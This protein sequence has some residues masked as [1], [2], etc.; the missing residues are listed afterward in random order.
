MGA[1]IWPA[2]DMRRTARGPMNKAMVKL[3][4]ERLLSC[5]DVAS[6]SFEYPL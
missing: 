6:E 4:S 5:A 3:S 2:V 1:L